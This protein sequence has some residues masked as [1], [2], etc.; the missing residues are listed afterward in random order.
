MKLATYNPSVRLTSGGNAKVSAP[1]VGAAGRI[2]LSLSL[3]AG[4][5][6]L[7]LE[8]DCSEL[9]GAV[10]GSHDSRALVC[11][12]KSAEVAEPR[13]LGVLECR[14]S[15]CLCHNR[16]WGTDVLIPG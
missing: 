6:L 8:P 14:A 4:S 15:P 5:G 1:D 16:L 12:A 11:G 13:V 10:K 3:P 2:T 9:E 7:A